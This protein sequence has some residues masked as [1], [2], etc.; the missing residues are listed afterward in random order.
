MREQVDLLVEQATDPV[1]LSRTW[2]GGILTVELSCCVLC[3]LCVC[4]FFVYVC[5]CARVATVKV[6]VFDVC[7]L[8]NC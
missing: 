4:F 2:L 8:Y 1:I 7:I 3:V 6:F 5:V